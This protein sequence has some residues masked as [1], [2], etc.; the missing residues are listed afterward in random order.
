LGAELF[1]VGGRAEG[2]TGM[3]KLL[4]GFSNFAKTSKQPQGNTTFTLEP[5]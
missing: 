2:Q 5:T 3:T 4:I 1:R